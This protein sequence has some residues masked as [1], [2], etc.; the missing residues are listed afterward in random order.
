MFSEISWGVLHDTAR[1]NNNNDDKP[2]V[3]LKVSLAKPPGGHL[4]QN[5]ADH[6]G[7]TASAP[8]P[9]PMRQPSVQGTRQGKRVGAPFSHQGIEGGH[10]IRGALLSTGGTSCGSPPPPRIGRSPRTTPMVMGGSQDGFRAGPE[11]CRNSM[12]ATLR[13]SRSSLA[14]TRVGPRQAACVKE[15]PNCGRVVKSTAANSVTSATNPT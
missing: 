10:Q 5:A 11:S 9:E 2:E 15:A 6:A 13:D 12:T 4:G 3:G 14:M 7:R 8:R 1:V